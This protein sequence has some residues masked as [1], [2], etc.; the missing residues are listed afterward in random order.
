M[1]ALYLDLLLQKL[2]KSKVDFISIKHHII[3]TPLKYCRM[4]EE[5]QEFTVVVV[6]F[7][8][9][10][11]VDSKQREIPSGKRKRRRRKRRKTNSDNKPSSSIGVCSVTEP[12]SIPSSILGKVFELN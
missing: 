6:L 3:S 7:K 5:G 1:K 10:E 12:L 4:V 11:H 8:G 2:E 9:K